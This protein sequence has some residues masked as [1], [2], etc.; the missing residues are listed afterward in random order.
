MFYFGNLNDQA[1]SREIIAVLQGLAPAA[2]AVLKEGAVDWVVEK[3]ASQMM[4]SELS[5][6][7]LDELLLVVA[8]RHHWCKLEKDEGLS[9]S[10]ADGNALSFSK[11]IEWV[12]YLQGVGVLTSEVL[13][14]GLELLELLGVLEKVPNIAAL[15]DVV[16]EDGSAFCV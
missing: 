1:V 9:L 13:E 10:D 8:L 14:R 12:N 7:Q 11:G 16:E 15:A 6:E 5:P 4:S 3:L 2:S